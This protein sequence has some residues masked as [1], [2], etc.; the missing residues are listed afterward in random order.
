MDPLALAGAF[1]T[2]VGLLSNFKAERSGSD[3]SDFMQW[4]HEQHQEHIAQ[5]ISQNKALSTEL[6]TLLATKHDELVTKITAI[7][8]QISCVAMQIDGF[9]G[10]AKILRPSPALSNQAKS[11]LRQIV[12]SGAKFV[13]EHKL[14]TGNPAEFIFI[15]G[16]TGKVQYDE[17][18][19]I[20]EDFETLVA[21]GL[22]RL[23][24]ASKGSRRFIPS[25]AGAEYVKAKN[26]G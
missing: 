5:A 11:I 1:A 16:A 3:L 20:N 8:D 14:G 25:R 4:L 9:S 18:Q 10:L 24:L 22:L 26:N 19:F 6:S 15:D 2:I 13:M 23:E 21:M 12:E 7:N 17:P